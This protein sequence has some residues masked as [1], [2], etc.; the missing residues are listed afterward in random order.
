MEPIPGS[1]KLKVNEQGIAALRA[2]SG[3]LAPVMVIGPYRSGK[4]FLI[5]QMLDQKCGMPFPVI[6]SK[7]TPPICCINY[8]AQRT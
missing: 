7:C 3:P 8:E 6:R 5:N 2:L 4:S 1:T